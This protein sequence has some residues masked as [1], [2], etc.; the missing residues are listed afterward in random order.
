M[1]S[2]GAPPY[3]P[4]AEDVRLRVRLTPVSGDTTG[5]VRGLDA[6]LAGVHPKA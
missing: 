1:T 6:W 2:A 4:T 5:I 3:E